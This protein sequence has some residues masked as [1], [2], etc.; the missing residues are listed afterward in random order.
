MSSGSLLNAL[1]ERV[2]HTR[3]RNEPRFGEPDRFAA[4]AGASTEVVA[5]HAGVDAQRDQVQVAPRALASRWPDVVMDGTIRTLQA[6]SGRV[7]SQSGHA[8][9]QYC[10][11]MAESDPEKP[12]DPEE[13]A[14]LRAAF[15]YANMDKPKR[16]EVLGVAPRTVSRYETAG[17]PIPADAWPKVLAATGLP[18]WWAAPNFAPETAVPGILER[19][20]AL[21][22]QMQTLIRR[23]GVDVPP[24]PPGELLRSRAKT[25]PKTSNGSD[26]GSARGKGAQPGNG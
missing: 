6:I 14:R 25:R 19:L 17:S 15:A 12:G 5:G 22:Y 2:L 3:R 24:P 21:E 18:S 9:S 20:E 26:V 13:A 23:Y 1:R 16:A 7:K 11:A 8:V 10:Q 4:D